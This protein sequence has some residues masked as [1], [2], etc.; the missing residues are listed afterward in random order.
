M[1][2]EGYLYSKKTQ[3]PVQVGD[4]SICMSSRIGQWKGYT[5]DI[6]TGEPIGVK[7]SDTMNVPGLKVNLSSLAKLMD[8][9]YDFYSKNGTICID[10]GPHTICFD[11]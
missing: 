10:V 3:Y 11:K 6:Q 5:T 1:G 8:K 2:T 4:G 7:L 9:G